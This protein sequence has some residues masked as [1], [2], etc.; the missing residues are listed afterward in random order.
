[1]KG[2]DIGHSPDSTNRHQCPAVN[3][4]VIRNVDQYPMAAQKICAQ[5]RLFD[6]RN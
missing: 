3:E 2:L 6:I 5:N 4:T 1:M